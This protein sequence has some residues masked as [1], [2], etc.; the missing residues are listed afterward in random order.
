M[1]GAWAGCYRRLGLRAMGP[2]MGG[3]RT[4]E[5]EESVEAKCV[6]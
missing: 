4:E 2:M 5:E 3:G 6:M 1:A